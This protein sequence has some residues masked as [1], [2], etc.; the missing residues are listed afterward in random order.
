MSVLYV[1]EPVRGRA[2]AGI[3]AG[4]A[5]DIPFH[6]HPDMPATPGD[7]RYLVAWKLPD[8]LLETLPRLEVVFSVGAG[9]DQLDLDRIPR[10]IPIVRMIEPA[11]EREMASY[12]AMAVLALHRNLPGYLVQQRE[13][14]WSVLP[15]REAS[16][17]R[18]GILGLGV[19]GTA[20]A[21]A[22]APFGFD[23]RG[24]SRS[25]RSLPGIA[26]FH[27][28]AGLAR[29]LG[30]CDIVACLLPLTP[31]TRGILDARRLAMLPRGACVVN[32]ARGG[33][34]VEADL[35]AALDSGHLGAAVLDV[36]ATEP[37]PADSPLWTHPAILL[38]PH[39]APPPRP[40]AD[41]TLALGGRQA[42]S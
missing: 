12:V 30:G 10:G 18:V 14:R 6:V 39:V 28:E 4:L 25:P 37:L 5:P 2:W 15:I 32:A 7:V 16:E 38:T 41:R 31:E 11:L 13:R 40:A 34:V 29:M 17:T 19:L 27:G 8:G 33:H 21:A 20:A 23:L 42:R 3:H 24:W 1:G 9:V 35:V 22:L 26:C 36:C